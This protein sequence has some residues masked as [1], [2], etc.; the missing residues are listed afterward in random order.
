[1]TSAYFTY[2]KGKVIQALRYHFISRREIKF[3]MILVNVF[4]IV[5]AALFF[6]KKISPLA[7]LISSVLWIVMMIAFWFFLPG[8]IYKKSSTFKEKFKATLGNTS[9]TI[10]N[11]R[12]SRDWAWNEFSTTLE[13]PHFFHLYFDSRSFFIIPKS[14]FPGDEEHEA[15]KILNSKI[16]KK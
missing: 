4:A 13:S 10:E 3:M 9:F 11:E 2:D 14:A 16:T 15:R 6:S 12:G 5:S 1:M 8:L 7:F